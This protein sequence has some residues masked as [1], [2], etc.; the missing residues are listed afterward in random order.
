MELEL[1]IMVSN[2]TAEL[3]ADL[4]RY[5]DQID[6]KFIAIAHSM[7]SAYVEQQ[8]DDPIIGYSVDGEPMYASV[9][10][11]EFRARL[12]AVDRGEYITLEELIKESATWIQE[13]EDTK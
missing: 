4:H 13:K 3:R 7:F 1:E 6:D 11:R 9:A 12:E 10:K 8:E 5:I 2:N